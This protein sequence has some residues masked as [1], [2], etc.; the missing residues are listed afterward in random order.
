MNEG[1]KGRALELFFIDGRPD[2]MLTAEVF[3][4]TGHV[5]MT[6]RTQIIEALK[7]EQARR[8]GVY[9][10]IGEREGEPLA[11]IGESE[12]VAERIRNH[13]SRKEWWDKAVLITSND[14]N[15]N[16]AHVKYLEAR[17]IEEARHA[18]RIVLENGTDPGRPGLSEAQRANM[19][20]FLDHVLMILPALRVDSFLKNTRPIS[21]REMGIAATDEVPVFELHA[22][23][24]GLRAT[25]RLEGGEFVV[26]KGSQA[27]KSWEGVE[28]HSYQ[29]LHD[30]LVK[31]G[32]L[33]EDGDIRVF[34]EN[35][36]FRSPSAAAAVINGR[37]A[38]GRLEWKVTG[39][40]KTYGDWEAEK[41]ARD[42][43]E[44]E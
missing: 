7:R 12:D 31:S 6:P 24:H 25:A 5:L 43:A 26:E 8:T 21:Q 37:A 27:R 30:E 29:A 44:G 32:V 28:S 3:N 23:R 16:K 4:W 17:L 41:L 38:N 35:Y 1:I 2:G 13:D 22:R 14:R 9:L 20:A 10:L 34:S 39:Q 33:R 18:A 42:Q 36:A 11:Y 15:L 40:R 19:E